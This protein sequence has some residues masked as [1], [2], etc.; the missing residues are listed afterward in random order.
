MSMM[1]IR[2]IENIIGDIIREMHRVKTDEDVET[3]GDN[4]SGVERFWRWL[5]IGN[6]SYCLGV[7]LLFS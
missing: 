2:V 4:G 1:Q 6:F 3:V 7:A 5:V